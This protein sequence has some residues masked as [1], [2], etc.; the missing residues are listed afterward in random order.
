MRENPFYVATYHN[1][2]YGAGILAVT[3]VLHDFCSANGYDQIYILPSSTEEILLLPV[4]LSDPETLAAMVN[5]VNAETVDP[6][7]QLNP[8]VYLY[9]DDLDTVTIACA[10]D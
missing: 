10:Y 3:K 9:D 4:M 6:L 1:K 2:A 7:L 8:T 5:S